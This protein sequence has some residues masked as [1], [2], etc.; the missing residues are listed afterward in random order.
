MMMVEKLLIFLSKKSNKCLIIVHNISERTLHPFFSF[1]P[2]IWVES[3]H[4]VY[5]S[6]FSL[7]TL[8]HDLSYHDSL[9]CDDASSLNKLFDH[10]LF[11][12]SSACLVG[13]FVCFVQKFSL[14]QSSR[15]I[16]CWNT[17]FKLLREEISSTPPQGF[18]TGK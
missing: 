15:Q 7:Y 6:C 10:F 18:P 3:R 17:H 11:H 4:F 12:T 13:C 14:E 2:Y 16:E 1:T 9:Y 5:L 8:L